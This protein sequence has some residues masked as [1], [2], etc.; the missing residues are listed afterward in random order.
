MYTQ[1]IHNFL[2]DDFCDNMIND[3]GTAIAN[4][5]QTKINNR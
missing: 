1:I 4:E 3:F 5:R 2:F